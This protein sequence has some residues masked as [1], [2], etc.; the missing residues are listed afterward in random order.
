MELNRQIWDKKSIEEL[1]QYLNTLSRPNKVAWTRNII[2]TSMPLL[3]I[4]SNKLRDIAKEIHKGNFLSFLDNCTY[5]N[6]EITIICGYL[7]N[8]EKDFETIKKYLFKYLPHVDCWASCDI[9]KLNNKNCKIELFKLA[10][11]LTKSDNTFERRA[12][13]KIMFS[14]TANKEFT[15]KILTTL[16]SFY[17]EKEYYVN[18][19]VAWLFCEMFIKE[20]QS[21]IKFLDNHNLN[22]FAIN[23]GIQKCRD[24]YRVT[25]EDKEM[26]LK[27]KKYLD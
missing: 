23:K 7:L 4:E 3:A 25:K 27:Y 18:M 22:N 16:N 5:S 11:E 24:S 10:L 13:L 6:Y 9:L 2:R 20:R 26:L 1:E 12:G 8:Y 19:M 15:D 21:T 17:Y 14:Y